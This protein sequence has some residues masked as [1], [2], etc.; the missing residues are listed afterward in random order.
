MLMRSLPIPSLGSF[1]LSLEVGGGNRIFILFF[2][3]PGIGHRA[4]MEASVLPL[5]PSARGFVL[6][7]I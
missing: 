1:S 2:R 3:W 5:D 7:G 4:D 6:M